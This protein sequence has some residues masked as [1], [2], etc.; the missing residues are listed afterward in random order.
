MHTPLTARYRGKDKDGRFLMV[1]TLFPSLWKYKAYTNETR[2]V[3]K[4]DASA[5]TSRL[6]TRSIRYG[7]YRMQQHY[8]STRMWPHKYF[9]LRGSLVAKKYCLRFPDYVLNL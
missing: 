5:I 7:I 3:V 8:I 4:F 2:R 9:V 1:Q 6:D